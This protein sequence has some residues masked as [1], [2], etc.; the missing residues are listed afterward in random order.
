MLLKNRKNFIKYYRK[1]IGII[2]DPIHTKSHYIK[3]RK[4]YQTLDF[5]VFYFTKNVSV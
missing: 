5:F 1:L 3:T 2:Q 4:L